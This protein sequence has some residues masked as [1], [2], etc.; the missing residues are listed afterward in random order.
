MAVLVAGCRGTGGSAHM[1]VA[2][3]S[4]VY[5]G[6]CARDAVTAARTFLAAVQAGDAATYRRCDHEPVPPTPELMR[7]LASSPWLLDSAA[8]TDQVTPP[9]GPGQVAVRIPLPD[10]PEPGRPLTR[11][12]HQ[13]GVT[14]TMTLDAD[15]TYYV[16]A[17]LL[18]TST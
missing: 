18:Y 1:S 7:E 16:T 3:E 2:S 17:V 14:I 4:T 6:S 12:P 15:G 9:T 8:R 10:T 5:A 13:S 11:P